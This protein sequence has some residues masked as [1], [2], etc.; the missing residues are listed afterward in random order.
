[1]KFKI[2]ESPVPFLMMD[3]IYTPVELERVFKELEFLQPK[4]QGPDHTGT[5]RDVDGNAKKKNTGLF[6]DD[7]YANRDISDILQLNRVFFSEEIARK[8]EQCHPVFRLLRTTAKDSTLV[9]YYETGDYYKSHTDSSAIT[10]LTWF[11][12]EPK[13]FSGGD[14]VFTDYNIKVPVRHNA[15]IIFFSSYSH[16]VTPVSLNDAGKPC[17][18][19]FAISQFCTHK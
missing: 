2:V 16:E 7:I 5:A 13:N 1:M 12:K 18:G 19:R 15:G 8:V 4:L 3:E 17:S 14:L 6:L 10:I 9:S 11:Y